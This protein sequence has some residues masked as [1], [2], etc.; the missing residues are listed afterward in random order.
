MAV[1]SRALLSTAI[2]LVATDASAFVHIVRHGESL[3]DIANRVY[4]D[5]KLET[6]LAGANFL[7]V[8]GG[9]AIVAG[10]RLEIPAPGHHRSSGSETWP[11][12]S[13][14]WLGDAARAEK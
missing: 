9:S 2:F 6:V 8:Q 1:R 3:A 10:M 11:A 5:S 14:D 4:G 13:Q 12:M 7:D